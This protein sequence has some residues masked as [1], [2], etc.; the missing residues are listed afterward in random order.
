M[1]SFLLKNSLKMKS[2]FIVK[3]FNRKVLLNIKAGWNKFY[4][5]VLLLYTSAAFLATIY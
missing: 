4:R 5:H 1:D 2:L 3:K